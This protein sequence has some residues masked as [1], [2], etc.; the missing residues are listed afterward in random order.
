MANKKTL[1]VDALYKKFLAAKEA[2]AAGK[3]SHDELHEI[4]ERYRDALAAERRAGTVA[5]P[6]AIKAKAGVQRVG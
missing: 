6:E 2:K 4:G 1:T 5:T 3:I